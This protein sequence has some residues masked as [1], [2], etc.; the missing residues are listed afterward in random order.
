[1]EICKDRPENMPELHSIGLDPTDQP[2]QN[3][4]MTRGGS[5]RRLMSGAPTH[6]GRQ[7]SAGFPGP[8]GGAAGF[9]ADSIR[10]DTRTF[11]MGNFQ[12]PKLSSQ[13]RFEMANRT[14]SQ[15]GGQ[16][17]RPNQMVRTTSQGGMGNKRT[18]SK[19]GE[20]RSEAPRA[21]DPRSS[22]PAPLQQLQPENF[23]PLRQAENRWDRRVLAVVDTSSPELVDRKVKGLLNKLTM[24]KFDSISDQI[25]AWANKSETE[26]DGRTL[27]QVIRLVFEKATDEAAWGEMYARLCRKMMERISA[28]VQDVGIK[29]TEGKP[30]AGGQLFRKYLLNR[31][32]EDFERGWVNKEITAAAAAASKAAES[33]QKADGAD[34][35][36]YSDEYYAAQ[37]AK[38]Q[39]LGLIRFIG[40]LFKLQMLTERI[41]HECVKKLLGNVDNPEEEEI[42]S[43]CKLLTT[44]GRL[45]DVP[46]AKSH[47]DIYFT[48]MT[49]LTKSPN[50]SSRM[51][52]M[53][54]DVLEL[55]HRNWMA[56]NQVAAPATLAHIHEQAAKE[57]AIQQKESLQRQ[58][59]ISMSRTGSRRGGERG[60]EAGP[61][62]W[63]MTSRAPAK[64]GD[65]SHFGKISK[66]DK[67]AVF[68]PTS[69]FSK[70]KEDGAA[71]KRESLSRTNSNVNMFHALMGSDGAEMEKLPERKR[72]GRKA[73]VDSV[74]SSGTAH[75]PKLHLQ[76]RSKP[77]PD[78]S[79]AE[80]SSNKADSDAH[81]SDD[82]AEE[83]EIKEDDSKVAFMTET[84]AKR[85]V[86]E[87]LKEFFAIRKLDEADE[88]F[89][90]LPP[91]FH[92]I[93]IDKLVSHAIESRE[94]D[95][96]LVADLFVR[97]QEKGLVKSKD[98]EEGFK[99]IAELLEDLAIDA[100]RAY[101]LMAIM[102]KGAALHEDANQ[103]IASMCP[104][105]K[106]KLLGLL[107]S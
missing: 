70:K 22:Y 99:P 18:R 37:K 47:M 5:G 88:Y 104:D 9:R 83:G 56:R 73:S 62:G 78:E 8:L 41:M 66:S 81:S 10:G 100:P 51:Q 101:D 107:S 61:D 63:T 95:A 68:A 102:M 6:L 46:K 64:A 105:G 55:R 30:I 13:D 76:P 59:N 3:F 57:S 67:P 19:R 103:R 50:V 69:V 25:I 93:L 20:A 4:S 96:R 27:I 45:L 12:A 24:E 16:F 74:A 39:G 54:Q 94:A 89:S 2:P 7:A 36:L 72:P 106:D 11:S 21:H 31:C 52:F 42:E 29:N 91:K 1:M 90:V 17:T 82:E 77:M 34:I 87:D 15:S 80:T 48:R 38:R 35:E 71:N 65:L 75:R 44:V 92:H 33:G 14:V 49:E 23:T 98:L 43:L 79:P 28:N 32:Q 58:T 40:E 97:A 86:E 26:K 85:R 60:G 84:D 53:L